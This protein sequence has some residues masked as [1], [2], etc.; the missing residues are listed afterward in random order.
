VNELI[1]GAI[2]KKWQKKPLRL[3]VTMTSTSL[4]G[5]PRQEESVSGFVIA[6]KRNHLRLQGFH[7]EVT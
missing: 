4:K 7:K 1:I 3:G 6:V 5:K 2:H